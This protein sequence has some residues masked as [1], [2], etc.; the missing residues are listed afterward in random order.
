MAPVAPGI[1]WTLDEGDVVRSKVY[2]N[3]ELDGEAIVAANGTAFFPGLGR[4][5]VKGL[6]LDSLEAMLDARYRTLVRNTAVQ[7]TVQRDLTLYG[8]VR[9]PGVYAVDPTMTLLGLVAR[10]GGP[11]SATGSP[12]VTLERADGR[13]LSLP[14]EARLGSIDIRHTDAIY[15]ADNSFFV[16]NTATIQTTS[17]VVTILSTLTG[18]ILILVR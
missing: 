17:L 1:I 6:T 5:D 9:A 8:Q 3:P 15:L 4:V 2:R 11:A 10:A 16:R 14:R 18:I 7:V 13:R 12:D